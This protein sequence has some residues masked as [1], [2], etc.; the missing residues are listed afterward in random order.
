MEVNITENIGFTHLQGILKLGQSRED[1]LR[2]V[3]LK[4]DGADIVFALQVSELCQYSCAYVSYI[5]PVSEF[6]ASLATLFMIKMMSGTGSAILPE[7]SAVITSE[8]S[9]SIDG[10]CGQ[11]SSMEPN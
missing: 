1:K 11:F 9:L 6:Y 4:V 2:R 3:T 8:E 7:L 10:Y 5:L